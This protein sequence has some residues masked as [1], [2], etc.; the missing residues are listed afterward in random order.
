MAGNAVIID[1]DGTNNWR[2]TPPTSGDM[3]PK[4]QT[5]DLTPVSGTTYQNT[6]GVPVVL[7]ASVLLTP[8]ST[9]PY[10]LKVFF[11]PSSTSSNTYCWKSFYKP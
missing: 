9:A 11:K 5:N 6:W 3:L 10:Y 7:Y 8:S 1:E 4:T 2:C